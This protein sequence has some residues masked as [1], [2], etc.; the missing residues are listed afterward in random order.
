MIDYV[1]TSI[2]AKIDYCRTASANLRPFYFLKNSFFSRKINKI[3]EIIRKF[4][5]KRAYFYIN[6]ALDYI[7]V[8]QGCCRI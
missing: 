8:G 1:E 4:G 2:N 6:A 3:I 7:W 5:P